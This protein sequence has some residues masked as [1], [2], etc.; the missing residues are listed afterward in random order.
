M[1]NKRYTS[2]SYFQNVRDLTFFADKDMNSGFFAQTVFFLSEYFNK[3]SV[4]CSMKHVRTWKLMKIDTAETC[5]S[6]F[7]K[8]LH[9]KK[10][11]NIIE[12]PTEARNNKTST[13]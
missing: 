4:N 5:S 12:K 7:F 13:V 6:I 9:R 1:S 2:H 11:E 8:R 3:P 10:E